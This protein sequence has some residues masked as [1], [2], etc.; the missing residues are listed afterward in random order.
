VSPRP[1]AP[2]AGRP[3][4][5][6]GRDPRR[7]A[8]PSGPRR[9]PPRD[10]EGL[11]GEQV[12]G[13]HAVYELLRARRRRVDRVLV[14]DAQD[15]SDLLDAIEREAQ[16]QRIPVQVVSMARLDR[17]ARTEGHQ[18]VMAHAARLP[19]VSLD[20]ILRV[21]HA[22]LLVCD[23][24]TDPRNLGAMLRSADGAGVTGVIV[25][26]HRSARV[27]PTVTKTAAGAIEY[28]TFC[29]VGGVPAALDQ[30]NRAGVFTVG[31]AGESAESIYDLDLAT[32]PVALVV[33]GEEKGLASLTRKR[34]A[35]VVAI[36]QFG[37]LSSLNAG[38]AVSVAAFEVARQRGRH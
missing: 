17:E 13:R 9:A 28:L 12:E 27:T 14:A 4:P 36:P 25:P 2:R 29:D 20:A 33:G 1:P 8:R 7:T 15:P 34:C 16:G 26:R 11:G 21:E 32:A 3:D 24:V 38:V 5:G 30:L 23:G 35:K 10:R 6:R 37:R 19:T 31:L 18:G 22:F